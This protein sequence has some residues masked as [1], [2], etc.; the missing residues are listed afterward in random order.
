MITQSIHLRSFSS[1]QFSNTYLY[2]SK[3]HLL[4]IIRFLRSILF[5][6]HSCVSSCRKS[7]RSIF[8]DKSKE[9]ASCSWWTNNRI[10]PYQLYHFREAVSVWFIVRS[11]VL[12]TL[13]ESRDSYLTLSRKWNGSCL[14]TLLVKPHL[15]QKLYIYLLGYT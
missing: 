7:L 8:K 1:F 2:L 3:F 13:I 10:C 14:L 5:P 4:F 9:L 6:I 12:L 11:H 15:I